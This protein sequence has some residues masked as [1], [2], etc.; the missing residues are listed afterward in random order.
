M[1][2]TID[3]TIDTAILR[4]TIRNTARRNAMSLDMWRGLSDVLRAHAQHPTVRAVEIAGAGDEAFVSGADI[5]KFGDERS[6]AAGADA[7][8][9]ATH[10][11]L[12]AV[13]AFPRP[14]LARIHGPCIGGGLM[15][16][17]ACDLRFCDARAIFS[18]P[19]A[20]LGLGFARHHVERLSELIG[21]AAAADVLL[22]ARR[23]DAP[24][25]LRLGLVTR[26]IDGGAAALIEEA[27]TTL[28]TIAGHAPMTLTAIKAALSDQRRP[29]SRRDPSSVDA[30]VR[31]C[32][33]SADAEEGRRAFMEKRSPV[34]RGV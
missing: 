16:A 18:I 14:V 7:Y 25:A 6:G 24:E 31:A 30:L 26:A 13:E 27:E 2:G 34:F 23:I 12:D 4:I 17:A 28:K 19:A 1:S 15:L 22:T 32:A 20:R 29:E 11:A 9:I 5:S 3:A 21:G 8:E 10:A 33:D